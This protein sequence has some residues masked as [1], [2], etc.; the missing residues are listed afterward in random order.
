MCF[1]CHALVENSKGQW[2]QTEETCTHPARARGADEYAASA[3]AQASHQ[4][5]L[6]KYP[7]SLSLS[8]TRLS[9]PPS[10]FLSLTCVFPTDTPLSSPP[11]HFHAQ[12]P[13]FYPSKTKESESIADNVRVNML[14]LVMRNGKCTFAFG[15]D[16]WKD[17]FLAW[18]LCLVLVCF[19]GKIRFVH[20]LWF[21]NAQY[22]DMV[23]IGYRPIL[24]IF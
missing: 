17:I 1:D 3:Q 5:C 15:M 10:F 23:A 16:G 20:N 13:R 22:I 7:R 2:K 11:S 12:H 21:T 24:Q 19:T 6:A 4:G 14:G 8:L 9:L 18:S